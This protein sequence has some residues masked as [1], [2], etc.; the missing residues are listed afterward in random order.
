MD[1]RL[2]AALI[3]LCWLWSF[4]AMRW[5]LSNILSYLLNKSAFKKRKK[6]MSFR[7]WFL[8]TRYRVELPK[9]LL[10]FYF[11]LVI[12]YPVVLVVWFLLCLVGPFPNIGGNLVKGVVAFTVGWELLYSIAFW[13]WPNPFPKYSRWIKKK[14]GMPP[15]KGQ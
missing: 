12:G 4:V 6:G 10:G 7:E 9:F 14:R 8:Y 1:I 11:F 2:Q 3:L 5:E 13:N 15:K